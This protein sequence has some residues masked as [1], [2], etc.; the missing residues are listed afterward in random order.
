MW[1]RLLA[2][3]F[4]VFPLLSAAAEETAPVFDAARLPQMD[5]ACHARYRE[6][7]LGNFPRAFAMGMEPKDCGLGTGAATT[8]G[9]KEEALKQC[10]TYTRM[11]SIVAVDFDITMPHRVTLFTPGPRPATVTGDGWQ[12]AADS[13]FLYRGAGPAKGA[14]LYLH[15][16]GLAASARH[17]RVSP[18]ARPFNNDGWDVWRFDPD[19]KR[20]ADYAWTQAATRAAIRELRAMQYRRIIVIGQ[21]RG[22]W[23][24]LDLLQTPGVVE[25]V[26]AANPILPAADPLRRAAQTPGEQLAQLL[27][28]IPS[29]PTRMVL[30]E[31]PSQPPE[32]AQGKLEAFTAFGTAKS[33]ST[34]ALTG[35]D[36]RGRLVGDD[37]HFN[38]VR[39]ACIHQFVAESGPGC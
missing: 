30:L 5:E 20:D 17:A 21:S 14:V 16:L 8:H 7:L 2:A 24:A 18:L 25:A 23:Q 38:R 29:Q 19:I 3:A 27:S 39:G 34:L 33:I 12:L 36:S 31:N 35:A 4:M 1:S 13:Q 11:C 37:E 28:K 15:D 22:G 6:F 32:L 10:G 26:I 9:A